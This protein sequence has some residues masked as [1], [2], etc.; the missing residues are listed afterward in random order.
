MRLKMTGSVDPETE[1]SRPSPVQFTSAPPQ[2]SSESRYNMDRTK[3][4]SLD[5]GDQAREE[6]DAEVSSITGSVSGAGRLAEL[7]TRHI[8][9][10]MFSES[11]NTSRTISRVS[12]DP[13]TECGHDQC[14]PEQTESVSQ[15]VTKVMRRVRRITECEQSEQSE[16]PAAGQETGEDKG[17]K[18][19]VSCPNISLEMNSSAKIR[20][21]PSPNKNKL[22][23]SSTQTDPSRNFLLY[24]TLFP[25][26]IPQSTTSPS[27][28]HLPAPQQLLRSYMDNAKNCRSKNVKDF[29]CEIELLRSQVCLKEF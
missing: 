20:V 17:R 9:P 18:R 10:H 27:G 12:G 4:L 26:A 3:L 1:A 8:T 21:E 24:E 14:E 6:T 11:A 16:R 28:K 13:E 19:R 2:P 15:L 23:F 7:S 29:S 25:Y 5:T 22:R